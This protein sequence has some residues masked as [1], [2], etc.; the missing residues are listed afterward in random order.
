[1]IQHRERQRLCHVKAG[2]GMAQRRLFRRVIGSP[3]NNLVAIYVSGSS[4]EN[5]HRLV[6]IWHWYRDLAPG[7]IGWAAIGYT[8]RTSLIWIDGNLEADRC[9]FH[10]LR[11]SGCAP[12]SRPVKRHLPKKKITQDYILYVMFWPFLIHR[13]FVAALVFTVTKSV[14]HWKYLLMDCVQTGPPLPFS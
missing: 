8:T 13:V 1:M 14:T 6:Y 10:N 3:C 7:V 4:K 12:T 2:S 5:V 11:S 9:I